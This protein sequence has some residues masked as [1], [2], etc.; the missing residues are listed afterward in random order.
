VLDY[1]KTPLCTR[2]GRQ[3]RWRL[4]DFDSAYK[5]YF[6]PDAREDISYLT[7]DL[8]EEVGDSNFWG[9]FDDVFC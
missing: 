8:P 1:E 6:T 2:H 9:A 3:H 5:A 7:D 4:V